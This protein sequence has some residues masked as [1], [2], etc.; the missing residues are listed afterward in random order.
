[1]TSSSKDCEPS[2][3]SDYV[4]KQTFDRVVQAANEVCSEVEVVVERLYQGLC[5]GVFGEFPDY[6][7]ECCCSNNGEPPKS[8]GREFGI[9]K[10]NTK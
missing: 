8:F 1:M 6:A 5:G 7:D 4:Q 3:R 9:G 10:I 2:E